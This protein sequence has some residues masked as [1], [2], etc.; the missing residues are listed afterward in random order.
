MR[1]AMPDKTLFETLLIANRGEI[2][3]RIM[4]TC[5]KLGIR[6]V[7]V[8]SDAD[9]NARH[10]RLA[11]RA[12]HIGAAA[13]RESYLDI[14]RLLDAAR[15]SGAQA[16]HPGYGFVSE[17]AGFA[18]ACIGAGLTF[19]GPTPEAIEAMGDKRAAKARMQ[20]AGVPVTLGYH[21]DHQEAA[22]LAEQA[23]KI[24]YPL[25]IKASAGG[26]GKGMRLVERGE[27]FAAALE[28]CRREAMAAF[29][30]DTVLLER[31]ITRPRHVEIQIFGDTRGQYVHLFE[32]DCSMQRRHQK[33]LEEA[34]APG[35][36]ADQREAM[37]RA[38]ITAA[39]AVDYVGAGTVEFILGED[40]AFH[41][42]EMNT[43]LQVEHPVTEMITGLDLVEW[44]LRVAAGQPLPRMQ[45]QI[46]AC[47]H[48]I[49]ARLYAEDAL[50][51]FLPSTGTLTTLRFPEDDIQLRIETGVDEGDTISPW[52]DP[53]IAKLIVRGE[54]RARAL[55]RLRRALDAVRVTGITSNLVFLSRLARDADF[56]AAK[57]DT[58]LI[59]RAE[60]TLLA[61]L[62]APCDQDW[63]W[64]ALAYVLHWRRGKGVEPWQTGDGWRLSG[65]A[66]WRVE[67]AAGD[68]R[69][70]VMVMCRTNDDQLQLD[71][72]QLQLDDDIVN[73][74]LVEW[75]LPRCLR[76]AGQA[77]LYD[78]WVEHNGQRQRIEA[79]IDGDQ[80]SLFSDGLQH[81]FERINPLHRRR[82]PE[83]HTGALTAPMPG[84]IVALLVEPGTRVTRGMPLL[85]MEAMKMEHTLTAPHDGVVSAFWAA[86]GELVADGVILVDVEAEE[87]GM[88]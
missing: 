5:R 9:R 60:E 37:A 24:G 54:D 47:G 53:M 10:V 45:E 72:Y 52:Y 75:G 44:Q 7:A 73:I 71:D 28:S 50:N 66:P 41:F 49:E 32:R 70:W 87:T 51:G 17:N 15:R 33:V 6:S 48:A 36:S 22:F 3:C 31:Y 25:L 11:D 27:D 1:R 55:A 40:G 62:P 74:R 77:T 63:R 86:E 26:G 56:S 67:L 2:A 34:P 20:A 42:M 35:L 80:I 64:A 38:A 46:N 61:A 81:T 39:R 85:V 88:A 30:D 16:V 13:A 14:D 18:R 84:R 82:E 59:A 68:E 57:L 4:R 78:I 65:H 83:T 79:V 8:H 69:R 58:G 21:G 29:G 19:V 43:R 23:G 76:A 12:I